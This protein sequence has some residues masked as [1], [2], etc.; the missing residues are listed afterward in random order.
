[1]NSIDGMR[2]SNAAP[3]STSADAPNEVGR[4]GRQFMDP[5]ARTSAS[6]VR[7]IF[8]DCTAT[9]KHDANTGMQRVVRNIVNCAGQVGREL[10]V[11]CRGVAFNSVAG[12]VAVDHLPYP[13]PLFASPGQRDLTL[14]Q[15]LKTKMK[16][17]LAR[18]HLLIFVRS[19]K[20]FLLRAIYLA[21][22]LAL[23]PVRQFSKRGVR[24]NR[25]DVFLLID[26][27]WGRDF[28]WCDVL[29]AQVRGAVVGVLVYDLTII[30]FPES[31]VPALRHEFTRWW[32]RVRGVADFMVA[33]SKSVLNDIDALERARC[34]EE[35]SPVSPLR[36]Y[37][38]LGAELD[39]AVN[40]GLAR[41]RF[42]SFFPN[43]G[44]RQTYLMVGTIS[45]LKNH[46]VVLD[47]FDRLWADAADVKL[48]ICGKHFLGN[49][50][51]VAERIRR[52]PQFGRK[53]F[54]SADVCDNELNDCYSR[55]AG[56]ITASYAE[57]F[58]LPIVEALKAGCPVLASDLPVHREVG[59]AY[60]AFFPAGDAVAL[61]DLVLRHQRVWTLEGVK[62]PAAFRW[63]DW[64][65]SCRELLSQVLRLSADS[66]ALAQSP[67]QLRPAA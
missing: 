4:R 13:S 36:G 50:D 16:G 52:H 40:G 66:P 20:Q 21:N 45:H 1:M 65:D 14:W 42:A 64:K 53:L 26:N 9:W 3:C 38:R 32:E 39:G 62:S 8:I 49:G 31:A 5:H 30:Y 67:P 58:N 33:I 2:P 48:A 41:G 44:P 35:T 10:G 28:P 57:G 29:Y 7:R 12:F 23:F 46:T 27:S 47:A 55:A 17:V 51:E 22:Y 60:A 61:A 43:A 63:P 37:F 25:G 15:K 24:F 34:R 6:A 56:L 18:W 59:G 11:Q 54:W 19:I